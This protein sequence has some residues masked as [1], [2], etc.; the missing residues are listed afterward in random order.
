MPCVPRSI[1]HEGN[2][3]A[4]HVEILFRHRLRFTTLLLIP[5][6]L[7]AY[8]LISFANFRATATLNIEDPASF[9]ATFLPI[10]WSSNQTAAQNL[11][12]SAAQVVATPGFASA[13]SASLSSSGASNPAHAEQIASTIGTDLK[14][15]VAGAHLVTITY[16]CRQSGICAQVLE[17]SITLFRQQL[18]QRQQAQTA[19]T[20]TFWSGQLTDA[21]TRLVAAEAAVQAYGAS[22]P[23]VAMDGTSTD[24]QVLGLLDTVQQWK[25]KVVAAQ[26]QLSVAEY[27]STASASLIQ[28]GTTTVNPPHLATPNFYGDKSSLLPAAL[29]LLA[30]LL[31]CIAYVVIMAAVDRTVGD[32]VL[33]ERRLG[34]RVVATIPKLMGSRG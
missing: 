23:N 1:R 15:S 18:I 12:D 4:R 11:A 3:M 8:V 7:A 29:V 27:L 5:V 22:H 24:P 28:L 20:S 32:P 25:A 19:A 9:G 14:I 31:A 16:S 10:G 34:V 26:D 6:V 2:L 33:L 21:Q 13:L 30:G 17:D